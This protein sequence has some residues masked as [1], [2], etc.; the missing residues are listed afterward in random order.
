MYYRNAHAAVIVYDCTK[1]SSFDRA[2]L[3]VQELQS[4]ASPDIIIA[5]AG[6]KNDLISPDSPTEE[7][8]QLRHRASTFAQENGLLFYETSALTGVNVNEIFTDIARNLPE[9]LLN[10]KQQFLSPAA[11]P[12]PRRASPAGRLG[13]LL[14][15]SGSPATV[16]LTGG[17]AEGQQMNSCAC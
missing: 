12:V 3:W 17:N 4:Q 16:R 2:Q 11:S 13:S 7:V 10:A 6:N 8:T 1:P 5:L 9:E 14:G 15:A